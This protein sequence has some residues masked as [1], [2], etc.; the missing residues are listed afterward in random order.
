M[1]MQAVIVFL[2]ALAAWA[3]LSPAFVESHYSSALY[4]RLQQV[5]TSFSNGVPLALF[6]VLVITIGVWW[7]WRVA[8]DISTHRER[9]WLRMVT[10]AVV[11]RASTL[12]LLYLAFLALW[13]LN[14]RRVPLVEKLRY[15]PQEVS[16]ARARAL[17]EETVKQLNQLHDTAHAAGWG[18]P[19]VVDQT[20]ADA[21]QQTVAGL[22][23]SAGTPVP[24]VPKATLLDPYFQRA[25]VAGMTDPY[26]PATLVSN[27]L[28][29]FERPAII[30][31]EWSHLAG[32]ADEGEANFVGWLAC[33]RGAPPHQYSG[34]LFLFEELQ[35]AV[36]TS[37]PDAPSARLLPGPR[38]DLLAIR[39]RLERHVSPRVS[40][41]GWRVYD[42]YLKANHIEQGA[43]SYGEVVRLVLGVRFEGNWVPVRAAR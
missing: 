39:Q 18:A 32:I 11:R 6:D 31:H 43:G 21:F 15:E 1:L 2:A 33:V 40:E 26:F 17:A 36:P 29:A 34:W 37:G 28:P 8:R 7:I 22:G 35:G 20:L 14:Y 5:L 4:P 42:G 19:R 38:G 13:G 16:A 3:P 24:G 41:A 23:M 30:A 12:A 27:D 10:A 9:G 25:G